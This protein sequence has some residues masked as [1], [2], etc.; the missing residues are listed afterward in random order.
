MSTPDKIPLVTAYDLLNQCTRGF[1]RPS[2]V[3]MEELENL[4]IHH[5]QMVKVSQLARFF[6][7]RSDYLSF[8]DSIEVPRKDWQTVVECEPSLARF[9]NRYLSTPLT[10]SP[11]KRRSRSSRSSSRSS[12]SSSRSSRSR[13]PSPKPGRRGRFKMKVKLGRW[14]ESDS[15]EEDESLLSIDPS[16]DECD[17]TDVNLPIP[18]C[19][20]IRRVCRH[21]DARRRYAKFPKDTSENNVYAF[22]VRSQRRN[23]KR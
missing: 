11:K 10:A 9:A 13:S 23:S 15:A 2:A 3:S 19:K 20:G 14:S 18:V 7:T 1:S 4:S 16:H 21:Y 12:R 17:E 5:R 8:R 22:K 6:K